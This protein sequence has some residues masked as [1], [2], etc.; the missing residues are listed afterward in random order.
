MTCRERGHRRYVSSLIGTRVRTAKKGYG[1]K[2]E[3]NEKMDRIW[4]KERGR[5]VRGDIEKEDMGDME[6]VGQGQRGQRQ[7]K[8]MGRKEEGI[9]NG[10]AMEKRGKEREIGTCIIE[11]E[12]KRETENEY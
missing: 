4:R 3:R 5:N 9:E 12:L 1:K 7:R 10:E 8:I 2:G 11:K 6:V